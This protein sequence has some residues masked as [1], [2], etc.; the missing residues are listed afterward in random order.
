MK[1]V[2]Y[3]AEHHDK[4]Y[5]LWK[6]SGINQ[7]YAPLSEEEFDSLLLCHRV[8]CPKFA[9]VLLE[10]KE[11][12]GFI[13]GCSADDI[14]EAADA[15]FFTC[16]FI[17]PQYDT[18]KNVKILLDALESSFQ[19]AGKKKIMCSYFNPIRLPWM[20][21]DTKGCQHNN[22]PGIAIDL[23]LYEKMIQCGYRDR[24]REC[25]M[26]LD[27]S[28][29]EIPDTILEKEKKASEEGYTIEW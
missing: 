14:P 25:A 10:E 17:L 24:V 20:I 21:P 9:F 2:P 8:F 6:I 29:F 27:L 15:G 26:Y 16:L 3:Q 11:I 5:E 7:G 12:C 13:C 18:I 28:G 1:V 19:K 23:P 4:V 22:A